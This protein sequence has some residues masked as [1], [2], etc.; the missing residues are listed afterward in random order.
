[1]I[2]RNLRCTFFPWPVVGQDREAVFLARVRRALEGAEAQANQGD[3]FDLQRFI[4]DNWIG[5]ATERVLRSANVEVQKKVVHKGPLLGPCP[6]KELL[7]RFERME[8]KTKKEAEK[9]P[10]MAAAVA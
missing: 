7:F 8:A 3:Y 4:S 2:K 1:M 6:Q 5:T 10:V 9:G